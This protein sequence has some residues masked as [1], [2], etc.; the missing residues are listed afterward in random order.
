MPLTISNDEPARWR[1]IEAT[2][3]YDVDSSWYWEPRSEPTGMPRTRG[4]RLA[5]VFVRPLSALTPAQRI[6]RKRPVEPTGAWT[7][8]SEWDFPHAGA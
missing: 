1:M 6:H 7:R 5:H 3:G 4:A 8:M 2:N